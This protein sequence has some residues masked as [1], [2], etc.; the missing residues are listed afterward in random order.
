MAL[1]SYRTQ[2][3]GGAGSSGFKSKGEDYIKSIVV[4][5]THDTLLFF[6]NKGL[7]RALK[8]YEVPEAGRYAK[9]KPISHILA[10]Q[11]DEK[12]AAMLP[13]F[14][15]DSV[16]YLLMVT[17]NG[18]VKKTEID[19]F[20]NIRRSGIVAIKLKEGDKLVDVIPT[21]GEDEILLA[22]R[23]GMAIRFK[24]SDVRPMGRAAAGVLGIRLKEYDYVVSAA[25]I[26]KDKYVLTSTT[27]GFVKKT[28]EKEYRIIKRGGKGII[29]IKLSD[30]N[31]EVVS[32]L[33]VDDGDEIVAMS[34][35][36]ALI[37]V[38]VKDIRPHG[39]ASM[40]VRLI[41]LKENDVLVD[42]AKVPTEE[43]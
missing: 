34:K 9:G 36:G 25:S 21:T 17:R 33:C 15:N 14:R 13:L 3:K 12:I 29:N 39:R 2:K 23:K 8:A 31:G 41:R 43:E 27:K 20:S 24:E 22:T 10:L 7:V 16:K 4:C 32:T 28:H 19:A 5:S 40:G 35:N 38:K 30:K 6:S 42:V 1:K 37:K 11:E 26:S 18:I